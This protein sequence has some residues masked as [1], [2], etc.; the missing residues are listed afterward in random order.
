MLVLGPS[1]VTTA[2][3][4]GQILSEWI[5]EDSERGATGEYRC[6][7]LRLLLG[8]DDLWIVRWCVCWHQQL[9]LLGVGDKVRV[10]AGLGH[11]VKV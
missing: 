6:W 1:Q 3:V 7:D 2:S 9:V 4:F 8:F 11:T 5:Y 10:Q